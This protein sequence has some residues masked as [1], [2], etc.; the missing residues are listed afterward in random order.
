MADADM[1]AAS[2]TTLAIREPE[3]LQQQ[4][5][6]NDDNL[7]EKRRKFRAYETNKQR[8]IREAQQA[9]RYYHGK[10][11]TDDEIARL[12]RRGQ[13]VITDN[14]I[15]RK[16]DFLIGVEQR[17][18]RDPKAY[19]RTPK[20][21]QSADTATAGLRYVCDANR[22]EHKASDGGH[23]GMVSGVGVIWVG[24][25]QGQSGLDPELK[26]C[27]V[28]RFFYDPRSVMPDFSDARYMGMHLW[29]DI[30]DA[31]VEHP[32]REDDLRKLVDRTGGLTTM[33]LEEDRSEQWGDFERN[34]VRLVEMYEKKP[35]APMASGFGW[36][37]CKFSGDIMLDSM[38]SPYVD[39]N[40]APD[41]PYVAWSPYIDE[42]GDRYGIVRNMR[43]MQD[44]INH[45]RS[46]LL[47]RINVR[48]V[49]M[50][51]GAVDDVDKFKYEASR[52]DGVMEYTGTWGEDIDFVDQSQEAK[53]EAD[54]L[55]QAQ[56]S[57]EN[58]GPNPGLIGKGG[59][60]ADQSGRAI[61]AQRDSG[62]TELS[63]VFE[64]L[65]DW[66]LRVYRK[67]WARCKQAWTSER[68]IRITDEDDAPAF[69]GINQYEQDPTTGAIAGSNVIAEIDVDIILDEGPDTIT[70]QEE[71][72]QTF[73]QLGEAAAG[74]L[75]KVMI[76]LSNVPRKERLLKMISEATAPDPAVAEMQQRMAKLEE[77]MAAVKIDQGV[78]DV[79]NKRADTLSKL[80]AA[81]TPQQ[82]Q[83]DEFGMP[84][85]PPPPQPNIGAAFAAMQA[86]PLMYGQPTVEEMARTAPGPQQGGPED[87]MQGGPMQPM[88]PPDDMP[89]DPGMDGGMGAGMLPVDPE[90]SGVA[91]PA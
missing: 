75:G 25:K 35:L 53:S 3:P 30:D 19:P 15:A 48:Q 7:A 16:I 63:P 38:W 74:P 12:N 42:R 2:G 67:I 43:P 45:R 44:E 28:D 64:R 73:S 34:R 55:V 57:L 46:K 31:V 61:L 50:R 86:F 91:P 78:A 20:D 58:L 23:D 13:P 68:W 32:D 85:G 41:C 6:T 79:E 11:W 29:V 70:M 52:P 8:E 39:E 71:L 54:L 83:V 81:S 77:L 88:P 9:R 65:R 47:H 90:M 24:I 37:Y 22:W 33:K 60:V 82:Q 21:E 76:E 27:Q 66:K 17:M 40:G 51:T 4:R 5:A 87:E 84:S 14:R 72:M 36:Y 62:M 49:R 26:S 56:S 80:M 89:I 10:Q 69:L 1:M 18:R 59:G